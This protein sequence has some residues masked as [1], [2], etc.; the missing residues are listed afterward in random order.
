MALTDAAS[1]N[2]YIQATVKKKNYPSFFLKPNLYL[3]LYC[4]AWCSVVYFKGA[5]EDDDDIHIVMEYC[6]GGELHH[7]IGLRSY[8]E[9][10]VSHYMRSVLHTLAQCHA[11]RILHRDIKPGNFMLLSDDEGAPLKAIDFGLAVFYDP[12]KLPRTDLGLDGTPWFMAPEV[13]NSQTYP[14]SDIW[15]AGVMAYQLLSGYL[16]FDDVRNPNAPALSIIWRGIL[17]EEPSF[18]RSA[19]HNV[20]E[21]AK[22]FVKTLLN[23]DHER[24]P[25]AKQALSHPWLQKE[26]HRDK[27]RPLSATVVQ[28]I[29]RYGQK[30]ILKRTILELLA[31]ELLKMAPPQLDASIHGGLAH[32]KNVDLSQNSVPTSEEALSSPGSTPTLGEDGSHHGGLFPMSPEQTSFLSDKSPAKNYGHSTGL[33]ED[34]LSKTIDRRGSLDLIRNKE[35]GS[36]SFKRSVSSKQIDML[37]R[38][39]LRRG[40]H[41]VHGQGEYWR[42]MR[43]ASEIA[44]M[45]SGHGQMN[46]IRAVPRS[47]EERDEARKAARLSLDTSTHGGSR[48]NKVLTQLRDYEGSIRKGHLLTSKST[49][50]MLLQNLGDDTSDSMQLDSDKYHNDN[51]L[52]HQTAKPYDPSSLPLPLRMQMEGNMEDNPEHKRDQDMLEQRV[53]SKSA[54][55]AALQRESLKQREKEDRSNEQEEK[56]SLQSGSTDEGRNGS[57]GRGPLTV[58]R[59]TVGEDNIRQQ[60]SNA[61]NPSQL[62]GLVSHPQDLE[63]LMRRLKFRSGSGVTFE[64]LGEGLQQLGY[65]LAP[66]EVEV[67]LSQLDINADKKVNPEEFVASQLDWTALRQNNRDLWLESARRAFA[68]L[69][70][71]SDGRITADELIANLKAKLPAAE[72]EYAL[73]DAMLEAGA[74]GADEIDFEGFLK[75]ISVGSVESMDALDQYEARMKYGP[76]AVGG[77]IMSRLGT[78]PENE[79]D[80]GKDM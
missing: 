60:K 57:L 25:T 76:D 21:E 71:N 22:D 26:F 59:K 55:F 30:N 48:Y 23:K 51:E 27:L 43:Q 31:T 69:D 37:S 49:G 52:P 3:Y 19:W 29:Q 50:S 5:W 45:S 66:T 46:Y 67:L 24:R 65:D 8:T 32:S 18:R 10:S 78:V 62:S 17:T 40:A 64:A 6:R 75:M 80:E 4:I 14:S 58:K 53:R 79:P 2:K 16:P 68:D 15:S 44:A 54:A 72:V 33:E 38:A 35:A 63:E 77:E 34:L 70:S 73:E 42:L 28:R 41:T 1:I 9:E 39:G 11:Q 12:S 56:S 47:E 36:G 61:E 13:L 74:A 20:S 7:S